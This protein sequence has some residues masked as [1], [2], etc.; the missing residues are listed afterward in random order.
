VEGAAIKI[1]INRI[2]NLLLN[3]ND[4]PETMFAISGGEPLLQ[5]EEVLK[6]IESLKT[7]TNYTVV[8]ATNGSLIEEGFIDKANDLGL[9]GINISFRHL[10]DDWHK[11]HT[12]GYSLESTV[13]A[14][15]LVTKKF[16]GM[17]VVS[18]SAGLDT[19]TFERMCKFLHEIN[20]NFVIKIFHPRH[21]EEWKNRYHKIEEIALRH[22]NRMDR[23]SE[24]SKQIK[25]IRYQIE[26]DESVNMKL[27]K[28]REWIRKKEVTKIG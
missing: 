20:P 5:R 26:E 18:L 19:A 12:G 4:D 16:K 28:G 24:F 21:E 10:D 14:L 9:D 23:T 17:S 6:L 8:L 27:I 3:F 2:I 11:W 7:E 25:S 1:S 13:D 22:F 15:K